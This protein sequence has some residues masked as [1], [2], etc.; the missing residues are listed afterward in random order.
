MIHSDNDIEFKVTEF[1]VTEN[2]L[3]DFDQFKLKKIVK[4]KTVLNNEVCIFKTFRRDL[5]YYLLK[6]SIL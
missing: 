4:G 3:Y 5:F 6:V 2:D 1:K